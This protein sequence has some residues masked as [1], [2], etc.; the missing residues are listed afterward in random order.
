MT[1]LSEIPSEVLSYLPEILIVFLHRG[2][3]PQKSTQR[4]DTSGPDELGG[5]IHYGTRK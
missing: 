1:M 3:K 2:A 5:I 4:N